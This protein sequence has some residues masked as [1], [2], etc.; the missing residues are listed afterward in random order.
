MG[1]LKQETLSGA[2]WSMISK[3]TLQPV[4]FVFGM[5]LARLISPDEMG[6]LGLTGLFFA[7]ASTLKE[8]G[9]GAALIRKQDRTEADCSTVFWYNIAANLVVVAIF[10]FAAIWFADFFHQPALLWITRVSAVMMLL[11]ATGSVHWTLYAARRDFK[12]PAIIG[13]AT[14]LAVM[15]ITIY[16]AYIGWSYWAV[17][18]Q[19]VMQGLL[20]LAVV[21]IISP[22]KPKLVFSWQ[23]FREF[24]NF[25]I[26]LSLSGLVWNV[27]VESRNLVI[28]KFYS[29]GQLA[30][31]DR[32]TRLCQM[33]ISLLQGPIDGIIYPILSTVQDDRKRLDRAYRQY[34]RVLLCP[35]LWL[36]VTI[37]CNA[38]S[39]VHLLYGSTWLP[40]VPYLRILCCGFAFTTVIRVN[41]NYLM[42]VGRTDLLLRREVILRTFGITA[43]LVGACF[44]VA[45]VCWAFVIENVFNLV[46]TVT[47]TLKV[48][49]M[50]ARQQMRDFYPYLIM[51]VLVNIPGMV[52]EYCNTPYYI[53][54]F[55]GPLSSAVLYFLV[56]Q[57]T[58]DASFGMIMNTVYP[59]KVWR[60]L[61][62]KFPFLARYREKHQFEVVL[63]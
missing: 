44:S 25:G 3:L 30:L 61:E 29:P 26:K 49:D 17:V 10:W 51:A 2:K 12:T 54:A 46:L 38:E 7:I 53:A 27:Y 9:L 41:H 14:T 33:P 18:M 59:S 42:V 47:Y 50:S 45:A 56:L 15:P 4:Q 35:S 23:S 5:I 20:S 60:R 31:Y 22:W 63:D 19:G 28:G 36:M 58:R 21:W 11:N 8:A 43:M 32:A 13:L 6:I 34:M 55:L 57:R 24:F 1:R 37:A 40:C 52:L 39:L 62:S 16:L 48:S